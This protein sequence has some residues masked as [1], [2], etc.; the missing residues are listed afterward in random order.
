MTASPSENR[1]SLAGYLGLAAVVLLSILPGFFSLPASD[2]DEAR[3]A[4]AA[5][6]M[7][8]TGD[9]VDIR[10]QE[11]ARH[12]KPA[13]IYWMQVVATQPFGGEDAPIWAHRI[14]SAL[15]ILI[16]A[17]ATALLGA[18][19]G[20]PSVGFVAGALV[21]LALSPSLEARI[22]KTDAMLLACGAAAQAALFF[23][24]TKPKGSA[25][26]NFIGAPLLFWAASGAAI[27]VKGPIIT[28]VSSATILVY[29][30]WTRDWGVVK[31]LKPLLGLLVA[32]AVGLPWIVL[33][34]LQTNGAFI[35][36]A[37][38]HALLGKVAESDDSHAGPL[39]YHTMLLPVTFF[40]GVLLLGLATGAAW[41]K[42]AQPAGI[43]L[44]AW[45]APTW[46]I[47]EFVATKLPHYVIP[48]FPAIAIL[49]ALGLKDAPA[50]LEKAFAR[51]A[52]RAAAA[53]YT[54]VA[55]LLGA[56]PIVA[57]AYLSADEATREDAGALFAA[58]PA[59]ATP[60]DLAALAAGLAAAVSGAVFAAKPGRASFAGVA[61]M[62][63]ILYTVV[64]EGAAPRMDRL[65]PSHHAGA[66]VADLGGCDERT[67]ATAGYRE[68]SNVFY[69]GTETVLGDGAEAAGVIEKNPTCGVAVIDR[70]ERRAF[71]EAAARAGFRTET[72]GVVEGH[73]VVKGRD[74]VLDIL[75]H[76]DSSLT[77]Q[78]L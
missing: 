25:A 28:M 54:L 58:L 71:D 20:G 35:E 31:R 36:E 22:A 46:L 49:A 72:V 75:V 55:L 23:L 4:Q 1:L 63:I 3:Y 2:R 29:G 69:L 40:P 18:R 51:W 60:I 48:A 10:F 56:V 42:R 73:N 68:P 5:R 70:S 78:G 26:P 12:V 74:L 45:A 16:A 67:T 44:I 76:E 9:Y 43:F 39:G 6:Q 8:E 41:L 59:S 64:F 17:M 30:L 15:G 38:G 66:V 53:L 77:K 13:G 19:I 33:I 50:V 7:M 37:V 65:W 11:Q 21:A 27:M 24:L 47:F 32:A 57:R 62:T 52:H 14:P 34:T 61:A